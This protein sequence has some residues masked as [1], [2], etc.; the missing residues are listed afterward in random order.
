MSL[1]SIK[2]NNTQ[3]IEVDE[4]PIGNS[5]NLVKS[6]G[7]ATQIISKFIDETDYQK[8]KESDLIAT[9]GTLY[10]NRNDS[11]NISSYSPCKLYYYPVIAGKTYKVSTDILNWYDS[12]S[13]VGFS[14]N[15]PVLNGKYKEEVLRVNDSSEV[16]YTPSENGYLLI[17]YYYGTKSYIYDDEIYLPVLKNNVKQLNTDVEGLKTDVTELEG[18][19]NDYRLVPQ[20]ELT[21][22]GNCYMNPD[23][24]H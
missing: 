6:G 10:L 20:S 15:V 2:L 8:I 24:S 23:S 22:L 19:F 14:I 5:E 21:L 3:I 13:A 17:T 7:V 9:E 1:N 4:Q 18:R 12:Y 16:F 11:Y